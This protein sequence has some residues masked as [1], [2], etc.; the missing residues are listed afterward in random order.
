MNQ[1]E[2]KAAWTA[3]WRA[4]LDDREY[5]FSSPEAHRTSCRWEAQEMFAAGVVDETEKLEMDE[6]AEAAYWHA[7]EE[8]VTLEAGYLNGGHYNV[9]PRNGGTCIGKII[10][11]TYSAAEGKALGGFEA[12]VFK[13]NS[14]R[15]LAFRFGGE[16]WPI[17][18]LVL[19]SNTGKQ[20]DLVLTAQFINGVVYP[21]ID[22]AD[23][24]RA[25]VNTAQIALEAHDFDAY[26]KARPLLL[27]AEF[28]SCVE[29]HDSFSLREDCKACAG[30]GFVPRVNRQRSSSA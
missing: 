19:T 14:G 12:R 20:F 2:L 24:Y 30:N 7:V 8:L 28:I 3:K 18:G 25:L 15:H 29:C 13:E 10:N 6:L 5:R 27:G 23:T 16:P 1:T 22:D 17:D 26:R 9:M 4:A 21:T 11:G